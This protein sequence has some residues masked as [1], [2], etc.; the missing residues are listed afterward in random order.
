MAEAVNYDISGYDEFRVRAANDAL[1]AN[2]KAGF[3]DEYRAGRSDVI[4]LDITNKLPVLATTGTRLLDIGVGCG[5]LAHRLIAITAQRA[6]SLTLIDSAE[7]LT[8]LPNAPHVRKV[9]GPF[10]ACMQEC[11]DTLVHFDAILSYSVAQY[12]FK[13][14]NLFDFVD[15]AVGL[16]SETG[17]LLI[18]DVPNVSMRKRFLDSPSGK[19]HHAANYPGRGE[20]AV[21]FNTQE[22][23]QID[24]AVVLGLVARARAS[25][26]QAFVVPQAPNL[27][28]ASRREDILIRRP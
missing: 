21:R 6:Q 28:M 1:S 4:L 16:L 5:E 7:M 10:P 11:G 23:G 27:P 25:G 17:A 26:L 9:V 19:A 20:P 13:E 14:G 3:P 8:L 12:I 15:K 2:Q 24:D 22:F 18:G